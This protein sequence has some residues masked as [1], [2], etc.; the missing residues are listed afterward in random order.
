M[1]RQPAAFVPGLVRF[2]GQG[3]P[4]FYGIPSG[5]SSPMKI[6]PAMNRA[7]AQA[8]GLSMAG[9]LRRGPPHTINARAVDWFQRPLLRHRIL[10]Q[11]S[12]ASRLT[13]GAAGFLTL[14]QLSARPET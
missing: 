14:I 13:A 10:P 7:D 11:S 12:S 8:G 5:G 1:Q 2:W 6:R 4:A 9:G 3:R